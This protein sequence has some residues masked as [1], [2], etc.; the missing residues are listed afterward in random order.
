VFA[1]RVFENK[2]ILAFLDIHPLSKGHTLVIP[3]CHVAQLE[4]LVFEEGME[5]FKAI[6]ELVSKIQD[7]VN[8][9]ASTIAINNGLESGQEIPHVHVHIIPRFKKDSGGP[10]H[11]LMKRRPHI[12]LDEM[13]EIARKIIDVGN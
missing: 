6:Y 12:M 4:E 11:I 7:A 3:K 1:H 10:I 8:A 9:P 13:R 2:K 5:L